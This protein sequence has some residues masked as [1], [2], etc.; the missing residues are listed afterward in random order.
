MYNKFQVLTGLAI[1]VLF[2]TFP[3]WY[4]HGQ[5][6]EP[7]VPEKPKGATECVLPVE[8]MRSEH[9][10]LLNEWRDEVIRTGDRSFD[11]KA[12]GKKYQRSLQKTCMQCHTSKKRFCDSCHDYSSVSPYCW[13]C[14]LVPDEDNAATAVPMKAAPKKEVH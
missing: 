9:M 13:D 3:I 4:N 2:V 14:H 12:S 6:N 5:A 1:F 11:I 10:Q 7:P 8:Q